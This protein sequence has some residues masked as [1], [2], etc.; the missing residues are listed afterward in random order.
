MVLYSMA[1]INIKHK[2]NNCLNSLQYLLEHY[3]QHLYVYIYICKG[4]DLKAAPFVY[5][6]ENVANNA[7]N[8]AVMNSGSCF[9]CVVMMLA[10]LCK[11]MH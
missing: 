11:T 8:D 5:V 2:E 10:M 1:S 7:L 9:P 6:V 4:G 3:L